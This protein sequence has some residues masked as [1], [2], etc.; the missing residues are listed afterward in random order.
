[1]FS[2]YRADAKNN[3]CRKKCNMRRPIITKL[4]GLRGGECYAVLRQ[5]ERMEVLTE[6]R[7]KI[8]K[9]KMQ[10]NKEEIEG[11]RKV[12]RKEGIKV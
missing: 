4:A 11:R 7:N 3:T 1:M 12:R 5:E 8:M 9:R 2:K 10:R 6:E